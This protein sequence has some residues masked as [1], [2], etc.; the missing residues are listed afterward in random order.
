MN[1]TML[2]GVPREGWEG[3][4]GNVPLISSAE[5]GHLLCL[6][7]K[8]STGKRMRM[9][10]RECL[11]RPLGSNTNKKCGC[12]VRRGCAIGSLLELI[13]AKGLSIDFC[14]CKCPVGPSW[15]VSSV[16]C[17]SSVDSMWWSK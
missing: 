16:M 5:I 9:K 8:N 15:I 17:L 13:V 3:W 7:P 12:P 10:A 1:K 11:H 4:E 6:S 14:L 2:V